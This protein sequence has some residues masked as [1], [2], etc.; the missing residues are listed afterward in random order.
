MWTLCVFWLSMEHLRYIVCV[1]GMT[2]TVTCTCWRQALMFN[3]FTDTA[4][5]SNQSNNKQHDNANK[6][7]KETEENVV[8]LVYPNRCVRSRIQTGA[9]FVPYVL[10]YV[11]PFVQHRWLEGKGNLSQIWRSF[12]GR[13]SAELLS[14]GVTGESLVQSIRGCPQWQWRVQEGPWWFTF[15]S[16]TRD[17]KTT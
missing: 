1:M 9:G 15:A 10:P 5:Q 16:S 12:D 17:G 14:F 2:Q 8:C 4:Y 7:P 3:C 6:N 13:D 11:V